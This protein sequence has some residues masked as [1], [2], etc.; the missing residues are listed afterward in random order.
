LS[1]KVGQVKLFYH[2]TQLE[3]GATIL[4]LDIIEDADFDCWNRANVQLQP[5]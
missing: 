2:G 5:F 4:K 1:A 3:A